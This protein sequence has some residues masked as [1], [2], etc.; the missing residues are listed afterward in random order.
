MCLRTLVMKKNN[1]LVALI[2]TILVLAFTSATAQRSTGINNTNPNPNAALHIKRDGSSLQGIIIP[3]LSGFDTTALKAAGLANAEKG[4]VFYDTTNSVFQYWNGIRWYSLGGNIS[5]TGNYWTTTGNALT[6][7]DTTG[8][9]IKYIGT[10]TPTPLIFYTDGKE[11][12]RLSKTGNLAIGKT[13]FGGIPLQVKSNSKGIAFQIE[14]QSSTQPLFDFRQ[15]PNDNARFQMYNAT[16]NAT[17]E[18]NA[19]SGVDSYIRSGN[20]GIGTTT[21]AEALEV[22]GNIVLSE[23]TNRSI[24]LKGKS[25]NTNGEN[26]TIK[27]GNG[28]TGTFAVLGGNLVLEAGTGYNLSVAGARGGNVYIKSGAN[29]TSSVVNNGGDIFFQTGGA[30]NTFID[31]MS[32]L[33]NGNVGIGT[34]T[35][36]TGK[37]TIA[38]GSDQSPIP[39]IDLL[40][41]SHAT[42]KHVSLKMDNWLILQD[43]GRNGIKDFNIYQNSGAAVRFVIDADGDVSIGNT[44]AP[45]KFSVGSNNGFQVDAIGNIVRINDVP[46]SFPATQGAANTVLT[47]DGAGNLSWGAVGGTSPWT[48]SGTNIYPTI[49]T[50]NVGIGTTTPNLNSS[51]KA[52]SIV[53]SSSYTANRVA[54]L[55]LQGSHNGTN[56]DIG[57]IDFN[58]FGTASNNIA[59]ISVGNGTG[60]IGTTG[61]IAFST[62]DAT[63]LT[64]RLRISQT[65][66]IGIGTT[67]PSTKLH[68]VSTTS[69]AFR[70]VDGTQANGKV[71]VS[72]ANGNASWKDNSFYWQN[73]GLNSASLS[74]VT[75]TYQKIDDYLTFTKNSAET[76]IEITVNTSVNLGTFTSANGVLLQIRIDGTIIPTYG[77]KEY[78]ITDQNAKTHIS[79]YSVYTGLA[80]GSHIVSIWAKSNA[81]TCTNVLLDSGG[82]GGTITVREG[83]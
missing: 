54:S 25:A 18:L 15:N 76:D 33:E 56:I 17:I 53:A 66:N 70:L 65:G 10:T 32:I 71:L 5:S 57:R 55:E 11:G 44:F 67:T 35:P 29:S 13:P 42:S 48:Q 24:Y 46:T 1:T 82:W 73:N 21:P 3:K 62:D 79:M 20:F 14:Q 72:D 43:L 30:A 4:L 63:A 41:T 78:G 77:V 59:R 28:G 52:L 16:N 27:A 58:S 2:F 40:P 47:N 9:G 68:L 45:S 81:G 36:N 23:G 31:R 60:T 26:L 74:G 12:M 80:A 19:E 49:L 64:E 34:I 39:S 61:Y 22:T 51:T 75:T 37:L 7:S 6:I 50:N 69:P 8:S 38:N 83:R